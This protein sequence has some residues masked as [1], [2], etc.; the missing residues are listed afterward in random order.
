[1]VQKVLTQKTECKK[2]MHK[3]ATNRKDTPHDLR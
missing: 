3:N 1:M 2:E